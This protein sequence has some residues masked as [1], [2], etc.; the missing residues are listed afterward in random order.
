MVARLTRGKG[1]GEVEGEMAD[2]AREADALR[3]ELEKKVDEDTEAF[4]RVMAGFR[5]PKKTPE[6]SAA[7]DA[8]IQ[9]ATKGATRVPLS[10][11]ELGL[12]ALHLCER[13]AVAGNARSA[14]DAGVGALLGLACVRGA[15]FNVRIN[16]KG[17]TDPG[18]VAEWRGK[19]E[20]LLAQAQ[21]ACDRA[22]A[23]VEKNL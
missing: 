15:G 4:N 14:S 3:S 13:V 8:A 1:Y 23:A 21:A 17:I 19:S 10:V 20:A 12:N 2:L 5:L 7:R 6:E 9:E 18:V 22:L 11:M 16:L